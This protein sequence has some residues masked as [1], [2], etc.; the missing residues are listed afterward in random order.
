M[1]QAKY[2]CSNE[3]SPTISHV[4]ESKGFAKDRVEPGVNI[5]PVKDFLSKTY[6]ECVG[7]KRHQRFS[8]HIA[9]NQLRQESHSQ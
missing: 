5:T 2:Q 1:R 7:K 4:V 6:E 3:T 9:R 8:C